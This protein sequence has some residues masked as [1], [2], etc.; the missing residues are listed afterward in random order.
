V[1]AEYDV[2]GK[3]ALESAELARLVKRLLPGVGMYSC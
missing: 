3:G 2:D 1:F